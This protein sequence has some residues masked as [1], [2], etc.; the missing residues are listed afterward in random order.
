MPDL[1]LIQP[2]LSSIRSG[3]RNGAGITSALARNRAF[4]GAGGH[5]GASLFPNLRMVVVT[6]LDPR[7]DPAHTLGLELGDALVIRNNG[8]RVTPQ[9]IDDLAYVG[10]LA[11]AALPDGPL[12]EIAVIHHTKCGSARLADD[13]F[14]RRY[15]E[16][17]GADES[18][19]R[20]YAIVDPVATVVHDVGLLVDSELIS[21]RI[22]VSGHVYDV[23]TG[24]VGT[25]VAPRAGT[26]AA[27]AGA[28][29]IR[30]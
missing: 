9:V 19:L 5:E 17:I 12:F 11:E 10:Q 6:C 22:T 1:D 15:A 24:L 25:A 16:R 29:G 8:G 21:P 3:E 13:T 26:T 27:P 23:D 4:A 20:E 7:V 28:E 14:R 2:D 18:R 30:G